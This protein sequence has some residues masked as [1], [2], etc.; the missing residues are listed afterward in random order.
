MDSHPHI[1][2]TIG[3]L[4]NISEIDHILSITNGLFQV[5]FSG[6]AA[7]CL[8]KMFIQ[9]L[10]KETEAEESRMVVNCTGFTDYRES[11]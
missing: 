5:T 8:D 4:L 10:S 7:S 1:Q 3:S 2:G 11:Q 9:L 6:I